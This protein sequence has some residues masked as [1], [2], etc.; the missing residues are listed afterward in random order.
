[1]CTA[2]E[3]DRGTAEMTA[4]SPCIKGLWAKALIPQGI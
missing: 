2:F 4:G 1:M 3:K